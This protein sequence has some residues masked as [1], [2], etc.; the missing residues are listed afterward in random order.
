MTY[1]MLLK[2][3]SKMANVLLAIK[4]LA[5]SQIYLLLMFLR[6]LTKNSVIAMLRSW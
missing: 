2:L 3:F 1:Y 5:S 6:D 4:I